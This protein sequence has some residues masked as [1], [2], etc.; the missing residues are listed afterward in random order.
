MS[1]SKAEE[2]A[3][4]LSRDVEIGIMIIEAED[5]SADNKMNLL[6]KIFGS[7]E[8]AERFIAHCQK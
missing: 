1:F 4:K 6:I 8:N 5:L 3:I 2:T 7:K